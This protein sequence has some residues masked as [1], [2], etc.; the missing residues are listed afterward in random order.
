MIDCFVL[1]CLTIFHSQS[2]D[3]ETG[4]AGNRTRDL[5]QHQLVLITPLTGLWSHRWRISYGVTIIE[6]V[7][8]YHTLPRAVGGGAVP[9]GLQQRRR[10]SRS[11][12]PSTARAIFS[13]ALM[14]PCAPPRSSLVLAPLVCCLLFRQSS[15]SYCGS[16]KDPL[17][18]S[19]PSPTQFLPARASK[20]PPQTPCET[21]PL[22]GLTLRTRSSR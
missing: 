2:S 18:R 3:T 17:E 9:N 15:N 16:H 20:T 1:F 7:L 13:P 4:L 10:F 21:H 22:L 11:L 19:P 8:L 5:R 12:L 6:N 14:T